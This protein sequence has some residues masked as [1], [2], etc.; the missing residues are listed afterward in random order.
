MLALFTPSYGEGAEIYNLDIVIHYIMFLVFGV[1]SIIHWGRQNSSSTYGVL[2][3]LAIFIPASE[4]I[5]ENFVP[6]RGYEFLDI[7]SGYA[8]IL[9]GY[10]FYKNYKKYANLRISETKLQG[11]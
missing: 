5:Q 9:S 10:L 6:G 7:L 8:G 2:F 3:I 4:L 1:I 11:K